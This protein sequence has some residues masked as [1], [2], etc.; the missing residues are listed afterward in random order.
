VAEFVRVNLWQRLKFV[1]AIEEKVIAPLSPLVGTQRQRLLENLALGTR[2][3]F[4][5]RVNEFLLARVKV[6]VP[7]FS[8]E[9]RLDLRRHRLKDFRHRTSVLDLLFARRVDFGD[10]RV[11]PVLYDRVPT[12]LRFRV[13]ARAAIAA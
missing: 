12:R 10:V 3:R 1:V 7:R 9:H 6:R 13:R 4:V 5:D 8:M 2:K 11:K